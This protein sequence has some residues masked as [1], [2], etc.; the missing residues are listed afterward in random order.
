MPGHPLRELADEYAELST[1]LDRRDALCRALALLVAG[2][3]PL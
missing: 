3:T 2:P 1:E